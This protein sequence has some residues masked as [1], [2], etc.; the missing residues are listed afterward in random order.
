M[1]PGVTSIEVCETELVCC[2]ASSELA[3]EL[4][5]R[6]VAK[7]VLARLRDPSAGQN[8]SA[9]RNTRAT[10]IRLRNSFLAAFTLPIFGTVCLPRQLRSKQE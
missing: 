3:G 9:P 1:R 5:P 4:H 6:L 8:P 10:R 2:D 7:A